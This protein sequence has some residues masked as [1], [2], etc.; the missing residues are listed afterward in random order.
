MLNITERIN[1][2]RRCPEY[3]E[4][5]KY[6]LERDNFKCVLCGSKENIEVDHIKSLALFPEMALDKNNG[7]VLCN[8]CHKKTDTY[9]SG[10]RFRNDQPIHPI[11]SGDLLYRINSL[12]SIIEMNNK[13]IGFSLIYN[14]SGNVWMAGYRDKHIN[15]IRTDKNIDEAVE[16]IFRLLRDSSTYKTN[17][18]L[19]KLNDIENE[20]M[21]T[22]NSTKEER[23]KL[24]KFV[25]NLLG[26]NLTDNERK[27]ISMYFK[28]AVKKYAETIFSL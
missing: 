23:G 2:F 14:I 17:V 18:L 3:L 7:R 8:K 15:I 16:K 9:G 1:K 26:R 24:Y 12:P 6:I 21:K 25:E 27:Q 11:L 10:S 19:N 4:W 5:K 13:K 28:D 20:I 22:Q